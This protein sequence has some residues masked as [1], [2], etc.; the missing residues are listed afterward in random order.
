MAGKPDTVPVDLAAFAPSRCGHGHYIGLRGRRMVSY[1]PCDCD[2]IRTDPRHRLGHIQ[3]RCMACQA[4]GRDVVY[5]D[6]PHK[7][8][9][10]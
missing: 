6:P 1:A 2:G 3:V 8:S 4:E 5:Y 10:E 7:D 9:S